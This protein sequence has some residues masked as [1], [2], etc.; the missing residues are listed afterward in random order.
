MNDQPQMQ[1]L[2]PDGGQGSN[3][4]KSTYEQVSAAVQT[5]LN[6]RQLTF[7]EL[8]HEAGIML[9]DDFEASIEEAINTVSLDLEARKV[10]EIVPDSQPQQYRLVEEGSA[11]EEAAESQD[12]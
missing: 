8:V 2:H 10:I 4:L 11:A 1:T 9:G 3:M 5:A 12:A 6:G 7:G